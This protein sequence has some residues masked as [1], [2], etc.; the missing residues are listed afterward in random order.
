MTKKTYLLLLAALAGSAQGDGVQQCADGPPL[1]VGGKTCSA[2]LAPPR[3][4]CTLPTEVEGGLQ[5]AN[6][7]TVQRAAN[8]FSWQQFIGLNWPADPAQ[9]GAPAVH[10]KLADPG[11]RVWETW[12]EAYEVYL[13]QGRKPADWGSAQSFP[14]ACGSTGKL[15]LRSSKVSDVVDQTLQ[16]LPATVRFPASLKDQQG[17]LVRYEIRLNQTVF[18]YVVGQRLYDGREQVKADKVDFPVGSQLVKAAWR[19]VSPREE[20]YFVTTDAC[21]CEDVA[22]DEPGNCSVK[23]M[24]LAGFHLMTKTA[25]APQWIWSTYEQVDNIRSRQQRVQPLNN[26]HCHGPHC[27]PNQQTPARVP[28]QLQREI[29]IPDRDPDCSQPTQ[30]VDN[31]RQ[32]NADLQRGLRGTRLQHYQLINT[33]WPQP[34]SAGSKPTEFSVLPALLGNTTMESFSQRTSSC[35]GCHAMSRT[36]KP[37]SYVSGDYSFTLNNAQ[38]RPAHAECSEVEA[39]LACSTRNLSPPKAPAPQSEVLAPVWHGYRV[40]TA[41]YEV[42]GKPQVG[43]RLHCQSC[44]LNGGGNPDAAWW[45]DMQKHYQDQPGGLAARINQCFVHSMNGKPLCTPGKDCEQNRHMQGLIAYMDWLSAQYHA[46][47]PG[48]KPARGYPDENDPAFQAKGNPARGQA[49]YTQKCA[50]CHNAQGEGRYQDGYF[51]PALWGKQSYNAS[52]GMA[53]NPTLAAFLHGNMPYTSGGMLSKQEAVDL[54]TFINGQCRPGQKKNAQ[55][56]A[57]RP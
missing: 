22:G 34:G 10:R 25:A 14:A 35:M 38:P 42:V 28:T 2:H 18:D 57:C 36:L 12:K 53:G 48:Q 54:A 24:G 46:K 32:L 8:L 43:N 51:R 52:A 21:V 47:Y 39:S 41:T 20:K 7:N 19:E 50:F 26:P 11:P 17:R 33:Q 5:Q 9:R 49:I 29:K 40:A 45:V 27:T 15:L 16:A 44:H 13:P 1:K 23:R 31:L 4:S 56:K 3:L 6:A 37:D 30:A 55:G